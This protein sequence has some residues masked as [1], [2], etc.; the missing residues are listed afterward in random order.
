ME[1]PKGLK[2]LWLSRAPQHRGTKL[3]P[4]RF[5]DP[6][7]VLSFRFFYSLRFFLVRFFYQSVP[8][9]FPLGTK[10]HYG[11]YDVAR[12]FCRGAFLPVAQCDLTLEKHLVLLKSARCLKTLF[13][14]PTLF[15]GAKSHQVK[16]QVWRK[17]RVSSPL[18]IWLGL[19]RGQ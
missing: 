13:P 15:F 2:I 16:Q 9:P 14:Q 7:G 17:Q 1:L 4:F 3:G 19:T 11:I 10:K 18:A 5:E 6:S 8:S 12:S